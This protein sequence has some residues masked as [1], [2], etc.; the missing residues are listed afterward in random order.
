MTIPDNPPRGL[1]WT[2]TATAK[3]FTTILAVVALLIGIWAN[4][5]Q[6]S[7]VHCVGAQQ[8]ADAKRTQA[9]AV[10]T[11]A[12]RHADRV[13]LEGPQ[14]GGPAVLQLRDADTAARARTDAVRAANPPEPPGRC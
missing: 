1:G 6:I 3:G 4:V 7:Y 8:Q 5:Q 10:A 13:L 12:E 11:D 2:A 9:I 14:P